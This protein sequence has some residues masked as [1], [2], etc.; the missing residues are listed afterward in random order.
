MYLL[1]HIFL[2]GILCLMMSLAWANSV[3]QDKID[4]FDY[5]FPPADRPNKLVEELFSDVEQRSIHLIATLDYIASKKGPGDGLPHGQGETKTERPIWVLLVVFLLF[6]AVAIVRLAFP[7]DFSMI[8]QAYYDERTLQQVSKEDN[9]LTSW[10]Y[11]FLYLIFSLALGLFI[12]LM[13]S[14]FV[15]L[16]IL[17]WENYVRTA[18]FVA[19]LFI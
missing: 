12:V 4:T 16:D 13:E 18:F 11:I 19:L 1:R 2:S 7:A 17:S 15:R 10:P 9:M 8:V 14:S 6:F 3:Q 5:V